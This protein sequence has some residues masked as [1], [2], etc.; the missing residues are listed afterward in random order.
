MALEASIAAALL[1]FNFGG[2]MG[3][4]EL[5]AVDKTAVFTRPRDSLC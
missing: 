2:T 4:L 3:A 5:S 1:A